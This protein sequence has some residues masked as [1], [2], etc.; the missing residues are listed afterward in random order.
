MTATSR[1]QGTDVGE[2][3]PSDA[4]I[5]T[6][7][8]APDLKI[9]YR[10]PVDLVIDPGRRH[11]GP[12][13]GP[14]EAL[15]RSFDIGVA[16]GALIASLPVW[17]VVFLVSRMEQGGSVLFS[18][19]RIGR[20]GR[21]FRCWKFRTMRMDADLVL[22]QL[23]ESDPELARQWEDDQKLV[24]DPRV[25]RLGRVLRRFDLDEIPQFLN[26]LSGEMSLVGPRPV[27]V[28]EAQRFGRSLPTVLSVRPGLTGAWQV[29]GRNTMTY[30]ER[31]QQEVGYVENRSLLGD[32]SICLR[33]PMALLR[34]NDGR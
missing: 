8:L 5:T 6:I 7:E 31:V 22:A 10:D 9:I 18:Q 16:A 17:T 34:R 2:A 24:R 29:S 33:T 23:L 14:A 28:D 27:V 11:Q 3:T 32:L 12:T 15:K 30:H 26:V 25:T 4:A 1:G 20:N 13:T 21:M 19:Q